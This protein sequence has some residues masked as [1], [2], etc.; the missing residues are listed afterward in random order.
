MVVVVY[1]HGNHDVLAFDYRFRFATLQDSNRQR[2]GKRFRI[3]PTPPT[4]LPV[5]EPYAQEKTTLNS[6]VVIS[7]DMRIGG[8]LEVTGR[9]R[10]VTDLEEHRGAAV[11]LAF[12]ICLSKKNLF[13]SLFGQRIR[14]LIGCR[15]CNL[16]I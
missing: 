1:G 4:S 6:W 16:K 3:L 5:N 2:L 10:D 13:F 11:Y 8:A 9:Y 14:M 7:S 15:T 12:P